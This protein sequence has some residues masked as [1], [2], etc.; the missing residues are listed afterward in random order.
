MISIPLKKYYIR[1]GKTNK[2]EDFRGAKKKEVEKGK[3]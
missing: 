2:V 3:T 1:G